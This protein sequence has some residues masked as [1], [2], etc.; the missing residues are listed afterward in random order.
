MIDDSLAAGIVR[1]RSQ[2]LSQDVT[3]FDSGPVFVVKALFYPVT[4]VAFFVLCL[5]LGKRPF[6]GS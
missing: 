3:S 6:T 4:A 5:W 2:L 1:P